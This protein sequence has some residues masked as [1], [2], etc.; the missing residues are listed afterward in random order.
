MKER[1]GITG[2]FSKSGTALLLLALSAACH[3]QVTDITQAEL[4]RRINANQPGLILDVRTPEEYADGHIPGAINIPFDQLG[5][6]H[7]EIAAHEGEGIVLYC[8]SGRRVQIAAGILE[9]KGFSKLLHL[10]GDMGGWLLNG[11][12]P[13]NK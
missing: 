5:S 4:M 1:I 13:I 9:T 10:A 11:N 8:R 7:K 6:R 3:T 12:L 2:L